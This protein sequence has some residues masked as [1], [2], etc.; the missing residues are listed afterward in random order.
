MSIAGGVSKAILRGKE[1]GCTSIQVFV[2]NNN[3]W[4]GKDLT[5]QEADKFLTLKENIGMSIIAHTSYL[6]NLASP[7]DSL[8]EKSIHAMRDELN[9]CSRLDIPNLVL[10]PGAHTGSGES[11]GIKRIADGIDKIYSGEDYP[12]NITLET[13]AGEGTKLGY[14]F[15]QLGKIIDLSDY[16]HKLDVCFD[17]CHT[18]AA[19]YDYR[20]KEGYDSTFRKFDREIGLEKLAA[21][22]L[23][24]SKREVSSNI[25]RH[26]H[27]GK[28]ELGKTP[29]KMLM[30]DKRF[31]E[32]PKILETPKGENNEW[33]R[34]NLNLLRKLAGGV[35]LE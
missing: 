20:S 35:N 5:T 19:G 28:G 9:R 27:I 16:S 29:F 11:K 14:T 31:I 26:Q 23:N 21:I 4:E 18:F 8:F 6:I 1:L 25:D 2:K 17:T 7:K 12:T 10:H 24:D 32:V 22:H 34:R 3:R 30:K 15:E 33:D 13:T